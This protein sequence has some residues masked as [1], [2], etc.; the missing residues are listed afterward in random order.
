MDKSDYAHNISM[1]T[2]QQDEKEIEKLLPK[3]YLE[4][5]EKLKNDKGKI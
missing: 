2:K 1:D 4:V 5:K 3:W